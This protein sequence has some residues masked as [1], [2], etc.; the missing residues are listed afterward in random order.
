MYVAE[1]GAAVDHPATLPD[2]FGD[3]LGSVNELVRV[4]ELLEEGNAFLVIQSEAFAH[5]YPAGAE[6]LINAFHTAGFVDVFFES[7]GDELVAL[8]YLRL[9]RE[10]T[11]KQTWSH[12]GRSAR[13]IPQAGLRTGCT[14]GL[15]RTRCTRG[16][17]ERRV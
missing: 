15:R 7:L 10:N 6:Q 9:W 4:R 8:E 13:Q 11:E 16:E 12:P 5:F 2:P 1:P 3:T 17:R 14:A